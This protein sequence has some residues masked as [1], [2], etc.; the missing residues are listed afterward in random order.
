M[1]NAM[2][3]PFAV[4]W[5][6]RLVEGFPLLAAMG[7]TVQ[8]TAEHWQLHAPFAPNRNDH[9]TAF[10]ASISS[11]ATIAG[12]MAVNVWADM[13]VDVVIQHG[14][15][16]FVRPL[17]SDLRAQVALVSPEAILKLNGTLARGRPARLAVEVTVTAVDDPAM[18]AAQFAGRYVAVRL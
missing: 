11:L 16:D 6:Q 14:S 7:V 5:Q 3:S 15:T 4:A 17:Q 8:G 9:G 12:W 10:G 13:P 18:T 2:S 1:T